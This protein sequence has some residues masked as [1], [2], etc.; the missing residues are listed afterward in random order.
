MSVCHWHT[1]YHPIMSSTEMGQKQM[2]FYYFFK[3][4]R[5]LSTASVRYSDYDV[6]FL[7][8]K[9]NEVVYTYTWCYLKCA[10][11]A[12]YKKKRVLI[13]YHIFRQ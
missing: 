1:T 3:I 12:I 10:N 9:T 2:N 7:L 13:V 6:L 8:L 5:S 11:K 4:E